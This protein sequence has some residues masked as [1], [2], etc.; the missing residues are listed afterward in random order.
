[1]GVSYKK[2][3]ELK[4]FRGVGTSPACVG[5]LIAPVVVLSLHPPGIRNTLNF[6]TCSRS[7]VVLT[8]CPWCF[9]LGGWQHDVRS[10]QLQLPAEPGVCLPAFGPVLRGPEGGGGAA[11]QEVPRH[12]HPGA[13]SPHRAHADSPAEEG[14]EQSVNTMSFS[15][16][17]EEQCHCDGGELNQA[18]GSQLPLPLSSVRELSA[19]YECYSVWRVN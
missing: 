19:S 11:G 12:G 13:F 14:E 15:P 5:I 7:V 2:S 8:R 4:G 1:M 18:A 17:N 9:S 6:L 10:L 3:S 16:A